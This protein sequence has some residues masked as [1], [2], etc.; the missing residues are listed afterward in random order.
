[1]KKRFLSGAKQF[2]TSWNEQFQLK[3]HNVYIKDIN[4]IQWIYV[5][6]KQVY[7]LF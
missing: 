5:L 3:E 1:M 7:M 4:S 6:I 2:Q